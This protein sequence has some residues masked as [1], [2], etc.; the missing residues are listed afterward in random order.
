MMLDKE[1][2]LATAVAVGVIDDA[3][4]TYTTNAIDLWGAATATDP[5]KPIQGLNALEIDPSQG[6]AVY[7]LFTVTTTITS[8]DAATTVQFLIGDATAADGTGF[9]AKVGTPLITVGAGT[10]AGVRYKVPISAAAFTQ[11]YL[12]GAILNE[13]D[14]GAGALSGGAFA[15]ELM[16]DNITL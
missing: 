9:A 7:A 8:A 16:I 1:L 15:C 11:R 6:H 5:R 2:Q 10:T 14:D 12:V 4:L 3:G 13:T